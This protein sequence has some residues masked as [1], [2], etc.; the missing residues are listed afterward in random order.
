MNPDNLN[1]DMPVLQDIPEP[2]LSEETLQ[3]IPRSYLK[4]FVLFPFFED[5]H[6]I[7]V[8]ISDPANI[9]PLDD[10]GKLL[11]KNIEPYLAPE[12]QINQKINLYFGSATDTAESVIDDL[13]GQEYETIAEELEEVQDL[14]DAET[15][16]PIIKLMNLILYQA[17][18][19]RASDIHIEPYEKERLVR[20]RIDGVL[21]ER[22]QPPRRFLSALISRIKI[23][24][25]LNI[26]EKRLPHDGRIRIK[27]AN[28]EVD[29]R[30]SIIPTAF[31][32]RV[33]LRLLDKNATIYDL[34][35]IG[36]SEQ[37][38]QQISRMIR[39]SHGIILVTG[40][41]GSGKST[42]LYAA[43]N[44]INSPD[45]N[46]LTI[47][48]PIEYQI[49]GIGQMQVNPK[50]DLTFAR[51]LRS[52]LRQDPDVI[53]IGEIRDL[54]TAEIAIQASLTG[55][56][57]FSTL[58]TN[59]SA[60]AMTRLVDM[61]IEPFLVSSSLLGVLAQRLVRVICPKCKISYKP[62]QAELDELGL[63]TA[64]VK[65]PVFYHGKGCESC[66]QTGYYG[67]SGIYEM[68]LTSEKI[69]KL[70]LQNV[71]S[72]MIREA[73]VQD[74]MRTLRQDGASKVLKGITT[75][76]EVLRVTQE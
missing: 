15:E 56:L 10:L 51:G 35:D 3:K 7:R 5:D 30:V 2:R 45:Q 62:A 65:N 67:R 57:V 68:L 19:S 73:S 53:M 28:K 23:M 26:A 22:V 46:I 41:T 48:D 49:K 13:S 27:I 34:E 66:F 12:N 17:V 11:Q 1:I 40:P 58:H 16:A 70:I 32:E 54:E 60:G 14:L 24:A 52:I 43:L 74:G 50:I 18:E 64:K 75:I 29:I 47:E 25:N 39:K 59:D 36:F 31:G 21:Y 37:I 4:R 38:Y 9:V 72:N 6:E 71:D 63:D 44:K 33:V 76:E 20:Y 8:A 69:T 55:H 61:G 42:T